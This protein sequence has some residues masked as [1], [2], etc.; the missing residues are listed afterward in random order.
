MDSRNVQRTGDMFYVYLP[1]RWCKK[2]NISGKTKVGI[3]INADGSLS[4]HPQAATKKKTHLQIKVKGEDIDALHK[5]IVASYISPA[6]SFRITLDN[7]LDFTKVLNQKNLMSLE[8]VE[9]DGNHILCESSMSV[10]DPL[11]LLTTMIRKTRNLLSVLVT[12]APKELFDRYE[13]EIDRSRVLIE[14]S[15]IGSFV[16][17]AESQ[18]KTVELYFM[19]LISK[20]LERLADHLV[21]LEKPSESFCKKVAKGLGLIQDLLDNGCKKLDVDSALAFVSF[22]STLQDIKVKDVESYDQRRIVRALHAISEV[23]IDWA[24]I[25]EGEK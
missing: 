23:V 14:K 21:S 4:I 9:I 5:L 7:E 17:P 25:K 6:D 2:Y 15:V 8:L 11:L 16:N 20:E 12:E 24:V 1:T 10:N 19:S 22:I 13:S 3:Q 18:H